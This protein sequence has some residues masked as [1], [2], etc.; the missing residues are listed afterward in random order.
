MIIK[1][2]QS[3]HFFVFLII[4]IFSC[5]VA[6]VITI[7]YEAVHEGDKVEV[8]NRKSTANVNDNSETK[9]TKPRFLCLFC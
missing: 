9:F 3:K 5:T 4:Q 6:E 8:S 2:L 7:N 1:Y